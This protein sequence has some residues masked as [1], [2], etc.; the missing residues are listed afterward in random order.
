MKKINY[1]TVWVTGIF[2]TLIVIL[3][4]IMTYKIKYEDAI[5]YK[6][7]YFY[8]CD[9][10]ICSTTREDDIVD[11]ST[12]YSVYKYRKNTPTFTQLGNNYIQIN[13][14]QE[15]V[16]YEYVK[17][18]TITRKYLSY[19]LIDIDNP[20]FIVKNK[21]DM[22]GI[23]D[24]T[25]EVRVDFAYHGIK[26]SYNNST[27]VANYDSKYGIIT[28]DG[29]TAILNFEYDDIYIFDDIIITIKD[30]VLNIL[31]SNKKKLTDDIQILDKNNV[32]V[33][34]EDSIINIKV[35][36]DNGFSEYKFDITTKK[37][38]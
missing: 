8:N 10:N 28:L 13:D 34:K 21:N 6:Y 30:N 26:K 35:N 1:K 4:M 32:G 22:Y 14:N 9:N 19:D 37:L 23:I 16:L 15:V 11:K 18:N 20:L 5:Y 38:I 12:I 33:V 31:D 25:G 29:Q 3:L 2:L 7:L 17:G 36:V 24:T 27:I